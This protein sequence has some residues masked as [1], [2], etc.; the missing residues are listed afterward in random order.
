MTEIYQKPIKFF[1]E[2][3]VGSP[4][5]CYFVSLD[6]VVNT[7][8][9]DIKT[10]VD[11]GRFF[12]IFAPRQSGK[13]TIFNNFCKSLEID[14][15]YIPI[16]LSFQTFQNLSGA[17]FYANIHRNIKKQTTDRLK[18]LNCK[19]LDDV[20]KCFNESPIANHTSFNYLFEI[21]NDIIYIPKKDYHFHR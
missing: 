18:K 13:T 12:T 14:P 1:E 16:L 17:E 5:H 6:N 15:L 3:G 21:L 9:Q 2:Q 7:K 20:I 19:E 11:I 10:M 4:V 8:N